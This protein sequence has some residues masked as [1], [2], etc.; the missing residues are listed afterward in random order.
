MC[1]LHF[2]GCIQGFTLW[3]LRLDRGIQEF[4]RSIRGF[5]P[6]ILKFTFYTQFDVLKWCQL[7][8][9]LARKLLVILMYCILQFAGCIQ[10]FTRW[11]LGLDRGIQEFVGSI[12]G[13][14]PIILK[15][16]FHTQFDV[17]KWCQLDLQL[18]RI[19]LVIL[20]YCIL[21]FVVCI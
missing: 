13:F 20:M 12:R 10:G 7:G 6:L 9:Q 16:T 19:L 18:A 3:I 14:D 2:A 4:V 15:F 5:D 8:L 17:L 1:I 21:H 11:N